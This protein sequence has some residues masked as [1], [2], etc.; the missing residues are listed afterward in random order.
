MGP[1]ELLDEVGLDIA[2]HAAAALHAAYARA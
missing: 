2:S 1:L